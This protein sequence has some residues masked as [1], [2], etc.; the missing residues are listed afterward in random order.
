MFVSSLAK[1]FI[2]FI[3]FIPKCMYRV[4]KKKRLWFIAKPHS[5]FLFISSRY[6]NHGSGGGYGYGMRPPP[7]GMPQQPPPAHSG[8]SYGA[9]PPSTQPPPPGIDHP[10]DSYGSYQGHADSWRRRSN[11]R[12]DKHNSSDYK[13][14]N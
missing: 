6:G 14:K 8:Y 7:Y 5:Y 13:S 2:P 1:K 12:H 3:A 11:E 4:W 9:L 10:P